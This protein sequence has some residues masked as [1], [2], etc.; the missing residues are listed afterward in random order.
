MEFTWGPDSPPPSIEEHSKAK[1]TVLRRYL[2]A[3]FDRLNISP[4]RDEF[5]LDLVDGFAGG[6]QFT[7]RSGIVSGTPLVML[8]EIEAA[9]NRFNDGDRRKPLDFNCKCYFVDKNRDHVEHLRKVLRDH[10]YDDAESEFLS[11]RT[12]TFENEID[13]ILASIKR[14]QPRAGRAI[15]LL[16][17]TGFAQVELGLIARIFDELA[18]AEIILTFAADVLLNL[19]AEKPE[20]IRSVQPLQLNDRQIRELIDFRG[21]DG[22]RA[23]MQRTLRN[24]IRLFTRADFDTPFFIKPERSRRALWF[25]HLSKHPTARDVMIQIH[26]DTQNTFEHYGTGGIGMLGM[27]GILDTGTLPVFNFKAA[28]AEQLQSQ[29]L[30]D[31][32]RVLHGLVAEGPITMDAIRFHLAN[33]TAAPFSTLDRA[34]IEL[35]KEREFD[36]LNPNDKERNARA[37]R[38]LDPNDRIQLHPMSLIPG[39]SRTK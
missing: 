36:V 15:F 39:L 20:I 24:H 14:R 12:G 37:L 9:R 21:Q 16:D 22:G 33:M 4:N 30:E 32:P 35:A 23:L 38:R 8:E 1:L 18:S 10:G 3:Y 29:L 28:D 27:D 19:L 34:I 6:G 2:R 25:V 13:D 5:K 26:W 17:Q 31:L 7:D 11:V